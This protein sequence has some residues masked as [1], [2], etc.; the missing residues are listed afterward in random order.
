VS[1]EVVSRNTNFGGCFVTA[2]Y[3]MLRLAADMQPAISPLS[4]SASASSKVL[5]NSFS[6]AYGSDI[7]AFVVRR[8][9]GVPVLGQQKS[10]RANGT[11]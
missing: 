1:L 6:A 2:T 11:M 5:R 7:F 10:E 3:V 9:V 4:K 8:S